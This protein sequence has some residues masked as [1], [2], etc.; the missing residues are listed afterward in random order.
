MEATNSIPVT[1]CLITGRE[2]AAIAVISV[3]GGGAA[4]VIARN[5]TSAGPRVSYRG[6][7]R[8]GSW[9]G[10]ADRGASALPSESVVVA[11]LDQPIDHCEV[12]CHGGEAAIDRI[13]DDLHSAGAVI[14]DSRDVVAGNC[15]S[16]LRHEAVEAIS[17]VTTTRTAAVAL[18]QV[19]GAMVDF[20][21]LALASFGNDPAQAIGSIHDQAKSMLRLSNF[22][23]HL[24][25]PWSVVLAG[26]PNV[27]KSSL[28]NALVG[29]QRSITL[30]R[31]GTTRDVL[32]A[33][34]V[35][36]GWP[37]R[38]SDTAGIRTNPAEAIERQ[39]IER[40]RETLRTADL[41]L[42]VQDAT[43]IYGSESLED[44]P[45]P[46]ICV[47][48]KVDLATRPTASSRWPVVETSATLGKGID[49]LRQEIITALIPLV[50]DAGA[51]IPLCERQIRGLGTILAADDASSMEQSLKQLRGY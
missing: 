28:I 45:S 12:H 41:V 14:I 18:D 24:T 30:D 9:H 35:I 36:D 2:R 6:D 31:P 51:P 4:D 43:A 33:D 50:P 3:C 44:L 15:A 21:T 39:G 17:K 13:L 11:F 42:W 38:L 5:F 29:Y 34:A 49:R 40:A 1:A 27:G 20:V 37:I 8:Y 25:E 48:N 32:H 47:F 22:G 7:V 23:K 46:S 10:S 26:A 19:R 16:L